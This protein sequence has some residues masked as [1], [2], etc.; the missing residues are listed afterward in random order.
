M[1]VE[2]INQPPSP[3]A[4]GSEHEENGT[5]LLRSYAVPKILGMYDRVKDFNPILKSSLSMVES[6]ILQPVEA[7]IPVEWKNRALSSG[8][9][10]DSMVTKRYIDTKAVIDAR[11]FVPLHNTVDAVNEKVWTTSHHLSC[12]FQLPLLLSPFSFRLALFLLLSSS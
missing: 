11:V 7:R 2:K 10:L 6:K 8:G 1:T 4:E 12:P 3:I 9:Q 5:G